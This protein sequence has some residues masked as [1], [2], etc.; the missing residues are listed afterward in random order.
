MRAGMGGISVAAILLILGIVIL[1]IVVAVIVVLAV[2]SS[3]G[4]KI[5]YFPG[6]KIP[7]IPKEL[8]IDTVK[9]FRLLVR[10]AFIYIIAIIIN[11]PIT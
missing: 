7:W 9:R 2:V 6:N 4:N 5:T 3:K 11:H 10:V 8:L 1:L